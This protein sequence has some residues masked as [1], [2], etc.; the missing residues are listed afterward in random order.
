MI[1]EVLDQTNLFM[2]LKSILKQEGK[3]Y[4][5]EPKFHVTAKA[6][7]DMLEKLYSIGFEVIE[8]PKVFFS[9]AVLL[10]IKS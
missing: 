1:H 6:F 9:R 3:L 10:K 8:S 2:E 4:I 7:R 5:I